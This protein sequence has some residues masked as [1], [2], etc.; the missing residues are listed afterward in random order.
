MKIIIIIF[1]FC[2][3]FIKAQTTVNHNRIDTVKAALYI[4]TGIGNWKR[5]TKGYVIVKR[6]AN[7]CRSIGFLTYL[8]KPFP[9][10]FTVV[11]FAFY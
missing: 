10:R 3:F 9:K 7:G 6:T 11:D 1:L 8:Y 4:T 5:F 2:P